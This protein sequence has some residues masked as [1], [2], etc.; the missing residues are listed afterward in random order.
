MIKSDLKGLVPFTRPKVFKCYLACLSSCFICINGKRPS[1][2]FLCDQ[3]HHASKLAR[4]PPK[5]NVRDL[6]RDHIPLVQRSDDWLRS[7]MVPVREGG[8]FRDFKGVITNDD[9]M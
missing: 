1:R 9:G 2:E 5:C 7:C 3:V 6:V 4:I 8:N